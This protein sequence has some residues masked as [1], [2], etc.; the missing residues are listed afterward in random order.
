LKGVTNLLKQHL[1]A[2]K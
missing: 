2:N 1:F